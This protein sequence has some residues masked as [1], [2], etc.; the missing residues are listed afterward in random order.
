M[1]RVNRPDTLHTQLREIQRRLRLL[2]G[3]RAVAAVASVQPQPL[4]VPFSPARTDDWP[5]TQSPDWTAMVRTSAMPGR[6]QV[7]VEAVAGAGTSGQARL[8]V[9]GTPAGDELS[10]GDLA[11]HVVE[12]VVDSELGEIVVQARRT[13]GDGV[14]RITAL[15]VA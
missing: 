1:T 10:V 5:G 11:R 6:F 7:V 8:V 9:N 12:V 4:P 14:V 2:E 15:L 3:T 13:H